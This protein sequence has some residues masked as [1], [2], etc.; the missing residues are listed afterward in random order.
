MYLVY[1][2]IYMYLAYTYVAGYACVP[3]LN[4]C[5]YIYICTWYIHKY[6]VYIYEPAIYILPSI[7]ICTWYIHKYLVYIYIYYIKNSDMFQRYF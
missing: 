1:I 2:C 7:Y 3:D 6:L 4:I 5:R